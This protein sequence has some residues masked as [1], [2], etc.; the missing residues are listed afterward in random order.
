MRDDEYSTT[1]RKWYS[2]CSGG[3]ILPL[4]L[5]TKGVHDGLMAH[6]EL[7]ISHPEASAVSLI[8]D[9]GRHV[10]LKTWAGMSHGRRGR[11]CLIEDVGGHVSLKTWAGMSH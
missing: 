6:S 5:G 3:M 2:M 9:V 4:R 7:L 8:E 11:A 10:S 1:G